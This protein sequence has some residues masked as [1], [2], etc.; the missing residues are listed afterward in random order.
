MTDY[1]QEMRKPLFF[2]LDSLRH[3][4]PR[5]PAHQFVILFWYHVEFDYGQQLVF[6]VFEDF[7]TKLVA[8]AVPHALLVDANLH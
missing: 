2:D 6:I 7:R 5:R 4:L 3:A 8:V 1:V